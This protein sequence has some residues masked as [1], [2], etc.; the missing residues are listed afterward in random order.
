MMYLGDTVT[1]DQMD[2]EERWDIMGDVVDVLARF[3]EFHMLN[4]EW[5][6][7]EEA[8]RFCVLQG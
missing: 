3:H 1:D 2:D 8:I 4:G 5:P 7:G 6:T